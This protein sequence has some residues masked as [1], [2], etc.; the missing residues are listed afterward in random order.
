MEGGAVMQKQDDIKYWSLTL[1]AVLQLFHSKEEGLTSEDAASRLKKNG[2]NTIQEQKKTSQLV[3]FLNQFKNPI[4]IILIIATAISAATGEW[5][6]ASIILLIILASAVLS[7][8]QE[9]SASNAIEELRLKVQIK[10]VVL[11]DGKSVEIPS[12]ELVTGDIVK[13]SSGSLV[14]ADGLVLESLYFFVGCCSTRRKQGG[15]YKLCFNG[16]ECPQRKRN[17][18]D[19]RNR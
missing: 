12:K 3:L 1:D 17:C 16:H 5:I 18:T 7:F 10:S 4:I 9:Y 6:D 14:P 8:F 19:N 15:A 2:E 13:L 11:R